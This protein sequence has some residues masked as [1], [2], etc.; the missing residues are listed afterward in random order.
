[1]DTLTRRLRSSRIDLTA[2]FKPESQFS[3]RKIFTTLPAESTLRLVLGGTDAVSQIDPK[4]L[5][6]GGDLPEAS[7]RKEQI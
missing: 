3:D 2:V 7:K 4:G 6:G 1:M 5:S